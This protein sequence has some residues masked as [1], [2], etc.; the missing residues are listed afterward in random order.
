MGK[1]KLSIR[2]KKAVGND[3]VSWKYPPSVKNDHIEKLGQIFEHIVAGQKS[4]LDMKWKRR[5]VDVVKGISQASIYILV[6][7]PLFSQA[8]VQLIGSHKPHQNLHSS[9]F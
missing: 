5:N 8:R 2:L 7:C 6:H 9:M 1:G 4:I 3:K